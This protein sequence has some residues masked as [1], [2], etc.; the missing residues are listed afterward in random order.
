[1][2]P[3]VVEREAGRLRE[4]ARQVE[5]RGVKLS[6][7]AAERESLREPAGDQILRSLHQLAVVPAGRQPGRAAPERALPRGSPDEPVKRFLDA[8]WIVPRFGPQPAGQKLDAQV[9]R[10][11]ARSEWSGGVA[12]ERLEQC[13]V[14][15]HEKRHV[16]AWI[17]QLAAVEL[18]ARIEDDVV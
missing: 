11:V 6:G 3:V 1:M 12:G 9:R 2:D 18:V 5:R 16:A 10:G 4:D 8:E 17:V 13:R 15:G 14:D 7:E